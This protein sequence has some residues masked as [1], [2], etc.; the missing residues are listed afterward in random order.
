M[1]VKIVFLNGELVEEIYMNQ[2]D[3][4]IVHGQENKVCK[5]VKSLYGLKQASK[6]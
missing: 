1:N 4:F 6:Q 3:E 5:L 2:L